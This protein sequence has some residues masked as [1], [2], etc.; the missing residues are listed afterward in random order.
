MACLLA[1]LSEKKSPTLGFFHFPPRCEA[2]LAFGVV[3]A[4][5]PGKVAMAILANLA[6]RLPFAAG[7][8]CFGSPWLALGVVLAVIPGKVAMAILANLAKFRYFLATLARLAIASSKGLTSIPSLATLA[9][10][11]VTSPFPQLPC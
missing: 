10:L 4:V 2:W 6:K 9:R 1:C 8:A 3:L 5:I 7:L 11:A